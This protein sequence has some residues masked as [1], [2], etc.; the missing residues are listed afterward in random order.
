MT[1]GMAATAQGYRVRER[2][3]QR[4][5]GIPRN[6][7]VDDERTGRAAILAAIPITFAGGPGGPDPFDGM[8]D[9]TA[10]LVQGAGRSTRAHQPETRSGRATGVFGLPP[11]VAG[12]TAKLTA[13][14]AAFDAPP[15]ARKRDTTARAGDGE[16]VFAPPPRAGQRTE[17]LGRAVP[18]LTPRIERRA[19]GDTRGHDDDPLGA[20]RCQYSHWASCPAR[21]RFARQA[22]A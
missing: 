10:R 20:C 17:A 8:A 1:L 18:F 14:P 5:R 9:G 3:C 11:S 7:V 16:H 15:L 21:E 12:M 6:E 19:A 4:V 2:V 13:L 22:G